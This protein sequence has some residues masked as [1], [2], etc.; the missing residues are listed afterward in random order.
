MIKDKNSINRQEFNETVLYRLGVLSEFFCSASAALELVE[1]LWVFA[2]AAYLDNP[3]PSLFKERLFVYLSRFCPVR[4]CIVRHAGFLIGYGKPAGDANAI[5]ET[6]AQVIDLL[7]RPLAD[8]AILDAAFYRLESYQQPISI[9]EPETAAETDLFDA[10][11]VIFLKSRNSERARR[12]VKN[13]LGN[14]NFDLLVTYLAFIHTAHYWTENHPEITYEAD[15]LQVLGNDDELSRLLLTP[16]EAQSIHFGEALRSANAELAEQK[17]QLHTRTQELWQTQEL[18]QAVFQTINHAIVLWEAVRDSYGRI[19]DF[20][21]ILSNGAAH[22]YLHMVKAVKTLRQL[23]DYASDADWEMMIN[24]VETGRTANKVICISLGSKPVYLYTHYHKLNDGLVVVQ[25]DISEQLN[26]EHE[27]KENRHL[28]ESV[29]NTSLIG[30]SF[31]SADRDKHGN[32]ID[33]RLQIINRQIEKETGRTDLKGKLYAEEYPGIK[34]VGLFALMLRVMETGQPEGMEYFFPYNS[35]NKWFSCMVVK[36]DDGL[37]VTNMDITARKIAEEKIRTLEAEQQRE[38]FKVSL[39]TLEEERHRISESLHNGVGQILYGI[40]ISLSNLIQQTD[41]TTFEQDKKYTSQLVSAA[42]VEIRRISHDLIP[43]TLEEFGL[44][45]AIE[46]I[47]EQLRD[48][49]DFKCRITGLVGRLEKYL[50]LAVFR[51]TQELMTNVVKHADASAAMV[52]II[53]NKKQVIIHV[54]DNGKGIEKIIKH[55]PGIGLASIKSKIK[56]LNGE[57]NIESGPGAGTRVTVI[58]PIHEKN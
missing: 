5:P 45:A 21:Y 29:F 43:A 34:T 33:F 24:T 37:V 2:T 27:L 32:I 39:E 16:D 6:I 28:M 56:L 23:P 17:K 11:S 20:N 31:V 48:G 44:K 36:A 35:I 4:Y 22:R 3:L 1:Q 50:E 53:I 13:A 12:A 9:P 25:E 52:N 49:V 8:A 18:I 51:T 26:A 15:V 30:M 38:I 47:C 14:R 40:K 57:V 42:L 19:I 10:L 46:D 58:V 55:K 7:K 54:N 41:V